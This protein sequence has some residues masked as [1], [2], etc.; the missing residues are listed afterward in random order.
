MSKERERG[1]VH[2][3]GELGCE[4]YMVVGGCVKRM[5]LQ[6]ISFGSQ[7]A[8]AWAVKGSLLVRV[9][10]ASLFSHV[11]AKLDG[12]VLQREGYWMGVEDVEVVDVSSGISVDDIVMEENYT[13]AAKRLYLWRAGTVV[14][15]EDGKFGLVN[16]KGESIKSLGEW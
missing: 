4:A 11:G 5:P 3:L 2:Q 9:E 10:F 1:R 13:F 15:A 7:P 8:G 14:K 12:M 16:G 6:G